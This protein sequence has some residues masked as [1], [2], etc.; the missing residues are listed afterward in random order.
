MFGKFGYN[1]YTSNVSVGGYSGAGSGNF[2]GA[3]VGVGGKFKLSDTLAVRARTGRR[4][5]AEDGA[6]ATAAART[7]GLTVAPRLNPAGIPA[8][9]RLRPAWR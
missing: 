8:R 7:A 9:S 4:L 6:A 1:S 2:S 3:L 5:P